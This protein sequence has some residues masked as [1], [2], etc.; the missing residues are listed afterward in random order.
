MTADE[1]RI[2]QLY[3]A[4][5]GRDFDLCIAMMARDVAWPDEAENRVL[6]GQEAVRDYFT[7]V[8]A[9]LRARYEPI[10]LYTPQAGQVEVLAR[11]VITSAADGTVWSSTRVRQ[12]YTLRD[13]MIT[14]MESQQ[15][16]AELTFPGIG[17]LLHRLNDAINAGDIETLLTC[18][19]P[20]AQFQ[21]KL[22][23]GEIRGRDAIRA[24]FQ[25]LFETLRVSLSLV[26]YEL[27]PD[28]RVRARLQVEARAPK[29]GLW[30]DGGV[31]IWY[32][33]QGGVIVEQDVDD[34]G[35]DI[36]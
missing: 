29:G 11:Q 35:E 15:D 25:H 7:N 26:D 19:A 8:T 31:T 34:S 16:V 21:D 30:Q 10:S 1:D 32:R 6:E 14:R 24:H 18:Y 33:L 13:Q 2:A 27:E 3:E 28:D 36:A 20:D 17:A 22:E 9:P 23:G 12:R 4:F 5:N